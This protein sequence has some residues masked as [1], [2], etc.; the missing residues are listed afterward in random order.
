MTA[1]SSRYADVLEEYRR[2][3][4]ALKPMWS[5]VATLRGDEYVDALAAYRAEKQRVADLWRQVRALAQIRVEESV[6]GESLA[7]GDTAIVRKPGLARD[8]TEAFVAGR[9]RLGEGAPAPGWAGMPE[10][11]V[12]QR[13]REGG[14]SD[15]DVRLLLTFAAAMDRAR[16]ADLLWFASERLF[17]AAPWVYRPEEV[18]RRPLTELA[19]LLRTHKVSQRHGP[20]AWAWRIIAES[21]AGTDVAPATRR[22]ILE[23]CGE[24]RELATELQ[25]ISEGGTDRFPLLRGPKVGAMWIRM[26]AYPGGAEI[27]SL[28]MLPVAVDVQVRKVTEYMGVTDTG[29]LDLDEARRFIR[30][31]WTADVADRGAVGPRAIDGTAAALDP[32]LW[33]WG[34]WGCTRCERAAKKLPIG[35]ACAA[36]FPR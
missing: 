35:S 31:A 6:L 36:G 13:M 8:I 12:A 15:A 29:G 2:A 10:R 3:K 25:S 17:Q 22:A 20:D 5:S 32:A 34:K 18:T 27:A 4:A 9:L 28:D 26:L 11:I 7:T 33:F 19:D 16:D 21:L 24:A 14:A 1:G 30:Q 23:G